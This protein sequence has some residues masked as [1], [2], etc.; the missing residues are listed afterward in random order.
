[1]VKQRF[2][3]IDVIVYTV[4][5]LLGITMLYPFLNML[6]VS[7][8]PIS[9]VMENSSMLFPKNPT[10]NAYKY[11]F[12]YGEFGNAAKI[13]VFI[14]I[15]GTLLN[16]TATSVAA[17]A[18]AKKDLPGGKLFMKYIVISMIFHGGMIPAYIVYRNL[19]ILNTIWVLI[20]P[21]LID[22]YWLIIMRNY[23]MGIPESIS[24]AARIDGS[25]EF[26]LMATII[27]PLCGPIIATLVL[28]Y[29]V[30]HWNA[31]TNAVMFITKNELMP[32]QVVVRNL[33]NSGVSAE[34]DDGTRPPTETVRAAAVILVTLPV[35]VAYPFLQKYFVQ[36]VKA[37]AVKG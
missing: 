33:Y 6:A 24:E 15:V 8:A 25:G 22:T 17:F 30:A 7:F 2:D 12:K 31:Y 29:G 28:V 34:L 37:G 13:T 20:I 9:E 16:L 21:G 19:G 14:T 5:G 26:R 3:W 27:L 32:L 18:L 4:L 35:I 1:M 11:I 36:G 23:I 10:L